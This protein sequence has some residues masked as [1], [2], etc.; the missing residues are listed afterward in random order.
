MLLTF[1]QIKYCLSALIKAWI[2]YQKEYFKI[3]L[4]TLFMRL[5]VGAWRRHLANIHG[6]IVLCVFPESPD[7]DENIKS[8][9]AWI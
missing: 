5:K 7:E 3:F 9:S 4:A 6:W 1:Y 2:I 8:K